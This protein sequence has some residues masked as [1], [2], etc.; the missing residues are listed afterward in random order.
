[1]ATQNRQNKRI[2]DLLL[3]ILDRLDRLEGVPTA[4]TEVESTAKKAPAKKA[5]K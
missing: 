3:E 5:A 1:M 2:L 4:D